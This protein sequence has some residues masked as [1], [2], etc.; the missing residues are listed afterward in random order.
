VD[1]ISRGEGEVQGTLRASAFGDA[2]ERTR[3][4]KG[5]YY[6][7]PIATRA[8]S[9]FIYRYVF[10]LCMLDGKPGF[11]FAFFQALWFR[12]LVDAKIYERRQK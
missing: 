11:Y 3:F 8:M 6:R 12:M 7:L 9:Y 1:Q 10:S 4:L 2:R 5:L